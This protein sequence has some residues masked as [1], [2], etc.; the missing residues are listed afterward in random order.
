M[1]TNTRGEFS[2]IQWFKDG[3]SELV[4]EYVGPE[5]AVYTARGLTESVGA[6]IGNT[7]RVIITDGG[8]CITFEWKYG[9]GVVFPTREQCAEMLGRRPCASEGLSP[10]PDGSLGRVSASCSACE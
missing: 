7:V 10:G 8:D 5:E 1:S 6:Q 9:E 3:S 4:K 2:V